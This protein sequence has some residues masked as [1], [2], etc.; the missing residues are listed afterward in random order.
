MWCRL[1]NASRGPPL[2]GPLTAG[3]TYLKP[4]PTSTG[5]LDD[6]LLGLEQQPTWWPEQTERSK[7]CQFE[8]S[9]R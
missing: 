1:H 6:F 7:Q 8:G 9:A 4:P 5:T 3:A 2:E